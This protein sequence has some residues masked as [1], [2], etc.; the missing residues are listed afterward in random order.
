[1]KEMVASCAGAGIAATLATYP[2]DTVR[3]RMEVRGSPGYPERRIGRTTLACVNN[4][5]RYEG[6]QA[7]YRGAL[8]TCMKCFPSTVFQ[9]RKMLVWRLAICRAACESCV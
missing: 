2:I 9:V 1:M 4:I 5:L 6:V 3:R 7:F 8:V